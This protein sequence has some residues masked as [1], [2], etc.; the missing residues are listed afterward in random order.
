MARV[1]A[2]AKRAPLTNRRA[3]A[4]AHLSHLSH[5][6]RHGSRALATSRGVLSRAGQCTWAVAACSPAQAIARGPWR[7]ALALTPSPPPAVC[8]PA[9]EK[10]KTVFGQL[11]LFS[12][13]PVR[14]SAQLA[15]E[16][17]WRDKVGLEPFVTTYAQGVV[18]PQLQ[19]SPRVK[20]AAPAAPAVP[21]HVLP[22]S[23]QMPYQRKRCPE[24]FAPPRAQL[25]LW[26]GELLDRL[27][28]QVSFKAAKDEFSSPSHAFE[29]LG[30]AVL[31]PR[32]RTLM[33]VR[34]LARDVRGPALPNFVVVQA[35]L[36]AV[37]VAD[38]N[39]ELAA[40]LWNETI[41]KQPGAS[42]P[43]DLWK[44]WAFKLAMQCLT[45]AGHAAALRQTCRAMRGA[46]LPAVLLVSELWWQLQQRK[47]SG[48]G[49]L[50][51]SASALGG[52]AVIA[53]IADDAHMDVHEKLAV[54]DTI[55]SVRLTG[56]ADVPASV[57]AMTLLQTGGL[58]AG[59]LTLTVRR[60]VELCGANA[61]DEEGAAEVGEV[62]TEMQVSIEISVVALPGVVTPDEP[63]AED[64]YCW[65]E[66][67]CRAVARQLL[68]RIVLAEGRTKGRTPGNT[69]VC[70]SV[71]GLPVHS[72]CAEW[73]LQ[74][75]GQDEH[76]CP[77]AEPLPGLVRQLVSYGLPAG[78]TGY[79][80]A[81]GGGSSC[82]RLSLCTFGCCPPGTT[83]VA[84]ELPTVGQ[85][86]MSVV[87]DVRER[88]GSPLLLV[89]PK[90][91]GWALSLRALVAH[92]LCK[93]ERMRGNLTKHAEDSPASCVFILN[94]GMISDGATIGG[95][96]L[97]GTGFKLCDSTGDSAHR[98]FELGHSAFMPWGRQ[99]LPEYDVTACPPPT[100]FGKSCAPDQ[101]LRSV[102]GLVLRRSFISRQ[103]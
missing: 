40:E 69:P 102:P 87:L 84:L 89:T 79:A 5:L 44:F 32:L 64:A 16:Q 48:I 71:G 80:H 37:V 56:G 29:L 34:Q 77:L 88:L 66:P 39:N 73:Q 54:G 83:H 58:P 17:F 46:T 67:L 19:L 24:L 50:V 47:P 45:E 31:L 93:Y 42:E 41:Q 7:R 38:S 12:A 60:D 75:A 96:S 65:V 53:A 15:D 28:A 82:C 1:A 86:P 91:V 20:F 95:N 3:S 62:G 78:S 43:Q 2:Y 76:G 57:A 49:L 63:G 90:E 74:L 98:L 11:R 100:P 10:F 55:V 36:A 30:D 61:E 6:S 33:M 103:Y 9:G 25:V 99:W 4:S 18:P 92:R 52:T 13:K 23:V 22:A 97:L 35:L 59:E 81:D 51:A 68:G 8:S 14:E 26:T 70:F 72:A 101:C 27:A 21:S 94:V 85:L